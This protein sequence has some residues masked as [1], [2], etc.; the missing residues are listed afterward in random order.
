MSDFK[1]SRP[2]ELVAGGVGVLGLVARV[3]KEKHYGFF[4]RRIN[5]PVE[6]SLKMLIQKAVELGY[7]ISV[8]D[9]DAELLLMEDKGKRAL[10][11][12]DLY[13]LIKNVD[14]DNPEFR[15]IAEAWSFILLNGGESNFMGSIYKDWN[16]Y[17]S[18]LPHLLACGIDMERARPPRASQWPTFESTFAEEDHYESVFSGYAYCNCSEID[19]NEIG[20]ELSSSVASLIKELSKNRR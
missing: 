1:Y 8:E 3:N 6:P 20:V 19:G 14:M 5:E 2:T 18:A 4:V 12:A 9:E 15:Y 11:S 10:A 16:A 17:D 13:P 7:L